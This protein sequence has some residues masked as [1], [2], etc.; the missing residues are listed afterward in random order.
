MFG[1]CIPRDYEEAIKLDKMNG[2]TKWQDCT[3]LEMLQLNE[4]KTFGNLGHS[5]NT[6]IPVGDKKIR[7]HLVYA[8]KHDGRHKAQLV[9]DGHLTKEPLDSVY[10]GVVSLR[11]IRLVAFLSELNGLKLWATDIGNAYLEAT[12]KEKLVITAGPEF[13]ELEGHILVIQKALY[14]LR[15]SGLRWHQRFAQVLK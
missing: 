10:S 11:G 8:V 13:K 12:T 2:N 1:Y 3:A 6:R 9:A 5:K 7:V 15:S 4:Y 14:S